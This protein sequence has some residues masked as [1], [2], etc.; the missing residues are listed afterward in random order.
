MTKDW[1]NRL[2][3]EMIT[4]LLDMIENE[5]LWVVVWPRPFWVR[6]TCEL[7]LQFGCTETRFW[8]CSQSDK[9]RCFPVR[10]N[11]PV[12]SCQNRFTF[13]ILSARPCI[14]WS[15]KPDNLALFKPGRGG[16]G[17]KRPPL[18]WFFAHPRKEITGKTAIFLFFIIMNMK[19]LFI[20]KCTGGMGGGSPIPNFFSS[21]FWQAPL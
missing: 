3:N 8:K 15:T 14:I 9:K 12:A 17:E 6:T 18:Y 1:T 7:G 16:R 20:P 5:V 13:V 4:L 21:F 10:L 2:I 11:H 19:R